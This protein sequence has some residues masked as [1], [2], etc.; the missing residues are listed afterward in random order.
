MKHR[1]AI[2]ADTTTLGFQIAPMIDVVFVIML[3]F[4]VMVGTVKV[5]RHIGL[6]LPRESVEGSDVRF[7]DNEVTIGVLEDGTVTLNEE[8]FDTPQDKALPALTS[9]LHRLA[10]SSAQQS[11][12]V[13]VTIQAEELASYE[14]VMDVL[15]SLSKAEIKNVT[16]TV[17][18]EAL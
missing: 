18:A 8:A 13:L 15:N 9:T 10:T 12:K 7:P 16:F 11:Q 3:F 1:H 14:R 2:H 17:G 4:M 5:E 6:Q